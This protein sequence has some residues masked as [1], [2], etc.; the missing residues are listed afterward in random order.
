LKHF[1]L[2]PARS[3]LSPLGTLFCVSSAAAAFSTFFCT[4]QTRDYFFTVFCVRISSNGEIIKFLSSS[5]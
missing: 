5:V 3:V 2:F 1:S 4:A